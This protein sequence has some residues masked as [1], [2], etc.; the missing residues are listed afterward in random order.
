MIRR[1]TTS[2][3]LRSRLVVPM[4]LLILLA[5]GGWAMIN[6]L[7]TRRQVATLVD[8]RGRAAVQAISARVL[9][10]RRDKEVA[11]HLLAA[12]PTLALLAPWA[13]PVELAELPA[14][15]QAQPGLHPAAAY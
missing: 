11:A 9:E 7:S 1:W 12:Q 5:A 15:L 2:L 10:Q 13:H 3:P 14:P 4:V 8:S 6:E